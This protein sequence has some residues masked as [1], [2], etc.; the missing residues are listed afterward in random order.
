MLTPAF[1][2][3]HRLEL[4]VDDVLSCTAANK[5]LI[6]SLSTAEFLTFNRSATLLWLRLHDGATALELCSVLTSSFS[7]SDERAMSE[8]QDF[9]ILLDHHDLLERN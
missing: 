2:P 8:V 1:A 3:H 5:L 7:I 9:L 4:N 6:L